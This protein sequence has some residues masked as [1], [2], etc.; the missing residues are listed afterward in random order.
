MYNTEGDVYL[1]FANRVFLAQV[2]L[3]GTLRN[4]FSIQGA[5]N[6]GID[7]DVRWDDCSRITDLHAKYNN[8]VSNT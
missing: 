2:Y 3:N 4:A 5:N 7:F 8:N 1:L 6:I